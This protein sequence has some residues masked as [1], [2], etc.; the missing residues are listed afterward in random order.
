LAVLPAAPAQ[1]AA[2]A[3]AGTTSGSAFTPADGDFYTP[4][5]NVGDYAN[6]AI[7]RYQDSAVAYLGVPAKRIMYRSNDVNNQPV[8]VTGTVLQ[9]T[10]PWTGGGARPLVSFAVGTIGQGDQCAPSKLFNQGLEYE[11][12]TI[13]P[14]LAAGESVVVTDYEG[15]GTPDRVHTYVN[16]VDEANAVLDAAIAAKNL[17]AMRLPGV[18]VPADGKVGVYGYSQGGGAAAAAA[19]LQPTYA[20]GLNLVGTAAGAPPANLAVVAKQIDGGSLAGAFGYTINGLIQDYPQVQAPLDALLNQRGKDVL[21]TTKGECIAETGLRF[22]FQHT[23][24]YTVSGQP[25]TSFLGVEPFKTIVAAQ[26]IGTLTPSAPVYIWQGRNDDLIPFAQSLQLARD[27]CA[28]G[29][30]VQ[31][32]EYDI[33]VVFPGFAIGHALPAVVGLPEAQGWLYQRLGGAPATDGCGALPK[34]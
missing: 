26:Q 14:L 34:S 25:A 5:T 9:P 23:S 16:R 17:G 3:V 29:A 20:P 21:A 33:P 12:A 2:P 22:G 4:A 18:D 28:K 15:L 19:E 8:A 6:G 30:D 1:A 27:W 31:F 7:I 32:K 13:F 11:A 24:D 10:A